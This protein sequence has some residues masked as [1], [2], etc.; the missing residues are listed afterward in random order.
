MRGSD[1]ILPTQSRRGTMTGRRFEYRIW[2][3]RTHLAH[4]I[5]QSQWPL[6]GA[7]RR[8]DIYL[9]GAHSDR[10]LVKLRDGRRLEIK[11]RGRDRGALQDW[12]AV[13]S[14][15]FPLAAP[16]LAS[17]ARSLGLPVEL[18]PDAAQS[19]AHL[20]AD[21]D[22]AGGAV[23][24]RT[25]RKSRLLFQ[26]NSCRAEVCRVSIGGWSGL[27]I[28]LEDPDQSSI[29]AAID[30]LRLHTC[31]NRSY[32]EALIR[33]CGLRAERR[34]LPPAFATTQWRSR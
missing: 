12:T 18:S 24:P 2:P 28:A 6:A 25:V 34:R 16:D 20:L 22:A 10:T 9:I 1:F 26:A 5:L 17:L 30:G 33:L 23:I 11:R 14:R 21:L 15:P 27:T 31:P 32:G 7:E 3:R 13:S 4:A 19:A 8:A 29:L